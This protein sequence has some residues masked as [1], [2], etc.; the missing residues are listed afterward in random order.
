MTWL[1][2]QPPIWV[3]GAEPLVRRIVA[4][5]TLLGRRVQVRPVADL[6]D[7][8]ACRTLVLADPPEPAEVIAN[9]LGQLSTRGGRVA[10][11]RLILMHQADPPPTLPDL[12]P[13][14]P[15]TLETFALED[16]A[17]RVLLAR[18]PLHCGLDPVFGQVP[19]L[20]LV[21][22]A[23]PAR[24]LLAQALRLIPYG[25][26]RPRV[27][28]VTAQ[29]QAQTDFTLAYPH[30]GEV[31]EIQW[32][33]PDLPGLAQAPPVSLVLVCS[34]P[35][36][37]AASAAAR[38]VRR[39]AQAQGVSPPILLEVG[40][41]VP[42]GTLADWD[43]QTFPFSYLDEACRPAVLFDGLGDE[44]A[45]TIHESYT[46]SIAAQ[47]RDPEREPAGRPWSRLS[48]SY[49]DANRHQAD[50]LWAKLA[51]M[52]CRAIQEERVDSFT[53]APL[54][55]ERLAVIEHLRWAADRHLDGWSYAPVRDNARR[56]HPQLIP[57]PDLS[58]PMKD[59]DRFAVRGVPTL[60]A[61]SGLGVVRMLILGLPPPVAD[62]PADERVQ[63]LAAQVLERLV[64]RY[65]DRSLVIAGTLADPA[66]RLVTRI[67]LEQAG[68]GLFLLCPQPLRE[69]LAT[70]PDEAARLDLLGLLTHA[71]RR[72]ALPGAG[73]LEHWFATRAEIRIC[74][75]TAPAAAG[76]AKRVVLDPLGGQVEW[77]FEY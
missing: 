47:G 19:H 20:L 64:A 50:H 3:A 26:W 5:L 69:T 32:V 45:R 54:E 8:K 6:S 17:A 67:A 33:G 52:D 62:C 53:F 74:L 28:V 37:A 38:T 73:E 4:G 70:Q 65:P 22:F 49:R 13:D 18:W 25:E 11:L 2:R 43:G 27:T 55:A 44:L 21:G 14:G 1:L 35:P 23:P 29:A 31:A 16:R 56:H 41:A 63:Q 68:A 58:E 12:D 75:G 34:D 10:P 39:L 42:S 15:I 46:D 36:V 59:L 51:V 24:A 60:L 61:R 76:A 7:L 40:D 30:A 66:A 57:Y 77:G 48:A 9:L 71:E 72:I